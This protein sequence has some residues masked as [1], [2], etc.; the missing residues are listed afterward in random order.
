M[1][2]YAAS[3]TSTQILQEKASVEPHTWRQLQQTWDECVGDEGDAVCAEGMYDC[4]PL[5]YSFTLGEKL[6]LLR[7]DA[8]EQNVTTVIAAESVSYDV[9]AAL[10]HVHLT[11]VQL[12]MQMLIAKCDAQPEM[13][14]DR[15]YK[16]A[17]TQQ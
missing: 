14:R 6:T 2:S 7:C 3:V 9:M 11:N 8:T 17:R 5:G 10:L 15:T 13:P 16:R 12:A 1:D 4:I